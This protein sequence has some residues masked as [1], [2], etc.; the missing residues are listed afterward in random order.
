MQHWGT[1]IEDFPAPPALE[2]AEDYIVWPD[3]DDQQTIHRLIYRV[4][5]NE[6]TQELIPIIEALLAKYNVNSF[7]AGCTEIHV[8]ARRLHQANSGSGR[9]G[10]L[11]PLTIIAE[12]LAQKG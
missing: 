7:V 2:E 9:Y 4:K 6:N 3:E 8:L 10:C 12:E 1:K 11:D 5:A